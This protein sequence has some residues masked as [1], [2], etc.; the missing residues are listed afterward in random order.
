MCYEVTFR[1]IDRSTINQL[2]I[3]SLQKF[4]CY[5]HCIINLVLYLSIVSISKK[6]DL[7]ASTHGRVDALQHECCHLRFQILKIIDDLLARIDQVE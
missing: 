2:S 7:K 6:E 5:L 3:N 4:F 1:V